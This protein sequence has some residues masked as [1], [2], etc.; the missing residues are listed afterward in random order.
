MD[1]LQKLYDVLVREGKYTKSFE[2]FQSKWGQDQAYK[3][4]VFDVV[5]RDG[6]YTK[7]RESFF[8]KYSGGGLVPQPEEP[9]AQ[10]TQPGQGP[11][12]LK[13][14][15]QTPFGAAALPS[16]PS[17]LDSQKQLPKFE[18]TPLAGVKPAPKAK[19]PLDF[20]EPSLQTITPE[21]INKNEE[22]V[23]PKMNYQFADLGFK[24]QESGA[25]GDWMTATAPN[26]KTIEISLDPLFSSKATSE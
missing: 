21:L 19:Q 1:E 3:D 22:F 2:E 10:P 13:K 26:G 17:F 12:D 15:E 5:T 16:V 4:K 6:L 11:I 20:L 14:K 25:T 8:Q 9:V 7:D 23:V 24:F 18:A